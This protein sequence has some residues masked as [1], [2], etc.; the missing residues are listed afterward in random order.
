M[1]LGGVE[2]EAIEYVS[3]NLLYIH[4][5]YYN[6]I[7]IIVVRVYE[8]FV[9]KKEASLSITSMKPF[10]FQEIWKMKP[11]NLLLNLLNLQLK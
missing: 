9:K 10:Q 6:F 11:Q 2:G 4:N 3:L 5:I 8:L 1:R 7:L